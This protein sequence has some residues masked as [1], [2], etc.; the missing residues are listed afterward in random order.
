MYIAVGYLL[1]K[2]LSIFVVIYNRILFFLLTL[3]NKQLINVYFVF[4][5]DTVSTK[6]IN[7]E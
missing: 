3:T 4:L 1:V 2:G 7:S 5:I 6:S